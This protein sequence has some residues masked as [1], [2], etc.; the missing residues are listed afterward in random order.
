MAGVP[1][2]LTSGAIALTLRGMGVGADRLAEQA[3]LEPESDAALLAE[4]WATADPAVGVREDVSA[5]GGAALVAALAATV[6]RR[7][8]PSGGTDRSAP[9][10]TARTP[11]SASW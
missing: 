10:S 3:E 9:G 8:P 4:G 2:D 6:P 5:G 1:I 11:W 7:T